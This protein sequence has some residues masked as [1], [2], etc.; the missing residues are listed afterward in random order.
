MRM[1]PKIPRHTVETSLEGGKTRYSFFE[2]TES[3]LHPLM[4]DLFLKHWSRIV[5]GPCIEGAVFEIQFENAPKLTY[6]D[7][8]FTVDPGKWHFHLCIGPTQTS[9]SEE[10][11]RM[12]PVAKAALFESRGVGH[13]RSWGLCFWNG[14]DEQMM[15]VF[16]PNPRLADD[17]KFLKETDWSRLGLYYELRQRLL[18]EAVPQDFET[19]AQAAWPEDAG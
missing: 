14:F 19:D 13:G 7:G 15:T 18:G 3:V 5:V 8:Y 11:C 17:Q 1:D 16:L 10:L 9:K 6:S 12:R 4:D 2:A